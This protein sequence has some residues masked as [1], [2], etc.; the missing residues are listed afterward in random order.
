M[1]SRPF[2]ERSA[3]VLLNGHV[4][5]ACATD[6]RKAVRLLQLAIDQIVVA[7]VLHRAE[8]RIS[9]DDRHSANGLIWTPDNS[10]AKHPQV[11]DRQRGGE[12][13]V[14]FAGARHDGK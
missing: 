8:L 14:R 5:N 2:G 4:L 12:D 1:L 7:L 6:T 9:F 11:V 13:V 3:L 10:D